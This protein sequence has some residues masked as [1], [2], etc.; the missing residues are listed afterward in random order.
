[1]HGAVK[2]FQKIANF[3][4]GVALIDLGLRLL[5][6]SLGPMPASNNIAAVLALGLALTAT[7]DNGMWAPSQQEPAK[8]LRERGSAATRAT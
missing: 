3:V 4:I 6:L 8:P 5:L 2:I 1:M 7:A